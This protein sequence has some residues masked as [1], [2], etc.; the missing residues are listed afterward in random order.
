MRRLYNSGR[1]KRLKKQILKTESLCR[2]CLNQGK[3]TASNLQLDHKHGWTSEDDFF[4]GPFQI[5]CKSCHSLKTQ[6]DLKE[7][8][9]KQ[10]T[11]AYYL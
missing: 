11:K 7:N 6:S 2:H 3:L 8:L 1:W 9:K 5:L 4:T 10:K